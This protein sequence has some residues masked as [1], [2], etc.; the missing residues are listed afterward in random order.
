MKI[1]QST[2]THTYDIDAFWKFNQTEEPT[3]AY[4]N[5]FLI[6]LTFFFFAL[7]CLKMNLQVIQCNFFTFTNF[8]LYNIYL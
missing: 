2:Q 1:I 6:N 3:F 5:Y 4:I 8:S 7:V